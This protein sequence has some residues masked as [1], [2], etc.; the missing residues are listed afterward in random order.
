MADY[1]DSSVAVSAV[2]TGSTNYSD[3]SA[4]LRAAADP[5]IINHGIAEVYRTLTGPL[6]LP[7][8]AAAQIVEINLLKKFKEFQFSIIATWSH[9]VLLVLSQV[10]LQHGNNRKT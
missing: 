1:F 4:R 10:I 7:P 8:K 5:H 6:K 3:A 2:F 9:Q